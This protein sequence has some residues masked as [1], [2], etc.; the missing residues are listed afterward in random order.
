MNVPT[1]DELLA[2]LAEELAEPVIPD[3]AITVKMVLERTPDKVEKTVREH[4]EKKVRAGL[5]GC[6]TVKCTKW[7][8]PIE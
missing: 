3:N 4:L 7:Y 1:R 8:Y 5:M 2:E 6:V